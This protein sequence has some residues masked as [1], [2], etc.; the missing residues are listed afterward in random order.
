[1]DVAGSLVEGGAEAQAAQCLTYLEAVVESIGHS[2]ADMVKVNIYLTDLADL[3][4][5]N[6]AYAEFFPGG[7]PAR[8]VVGVSEL[9]GG[10]SVMIDGVLSNACLLYT[11]RCV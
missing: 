3:D 4:A 7:V 5:V 8:R 9:P 1:M 10:A 2:L 6:R 11:S